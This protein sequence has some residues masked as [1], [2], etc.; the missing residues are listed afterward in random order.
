MQ[1]SYKQ[2]FAFIFKLLRPFPF[3]VAI[4]LSSILLTATVAGTLQN[5]KAVAQGGP[6]ANT[7][8]LGNPFYVAH[9]KITSLHPTNETGK[10]EA[11][12]TLS[13]IAK[14]IN[15]TDSGSFSLVTRADG[16]HYGQGQGAL[17]TKGGDSAPFTF[18]L[19]GST[20]SEGKS[21]DHG[22]WYVSSPATGKLT[23]LNNEALLFKD[24]IQKN[25]TISL[26]GWEW[27]K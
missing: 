4:T 6:D 10:M 14:G 3:V 16:I 17:V 19:I 21:I 13:A 26:L 23:F 5:Q 7:I 1:K 8:I 27:N 22:S 2:V 24:E 25:G 20:D 15:V 11:T 18:Q 9:G 12:Y